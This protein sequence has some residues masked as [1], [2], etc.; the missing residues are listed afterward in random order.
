MLLFLFILSSI[1]AETCDML[2][3]PKKI[4]H[5]STEVSCANSSSLKECQRMI[6]HKENNKDKVVSEAQSCC[7]NEKKCL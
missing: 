5:L 1:S 3:A 6:F 7:E 4:Q 2:Y